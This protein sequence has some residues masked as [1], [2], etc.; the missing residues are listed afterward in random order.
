MGISV[1]CSEEELEYV[2]DDV[3]NNVEFGITNPHMFP[4]FV[5]QSLKARHVESHWHGLLKLKLRQ[6]V[7][8]QSKPP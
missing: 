2:V 1:G 4:A 3:A 6:S 8:R 5:Q 7:G